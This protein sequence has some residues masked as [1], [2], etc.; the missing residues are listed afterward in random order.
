MKKKIIL[1]LS[2]VFLLAFVSVGI[3]RSSNSIE[4]F[5]FQGE[6]IEQDVTEGVTKLSTGTTRLDIKNLPYVFENTVFEV[7]TGKTFYKAEIRLYFRNGNI[8]SL[9]VFEPAFTLTRVLLTGKPKL[10]KIEIIVYYYNKIELGPWEPPV[11]IVLNPN[12]EVKLEDISTGFLNALLNAKDDI[13][14]GSAEQELINDWPR[15]EKYYDEPKLTKANNLLGK[16][17]DNSLRTLPVD[18]LTTLG[19][20]SDKDIVVYSLI[21]SKA[22]H[23]A[24]QKEILDLF[25]SESENIT[26]RNDHIAMILNQLHTHGSLLNSEMNVLVPGVQNVLNEAFEVEISTGQDL[27]YHAIEFGT[28][29]K[30]GFVAEFNLWGE[31]LYYNIIIYEK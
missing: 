4:V 11:V 24:E 8:E 16:N 28:N 22:E 25:W 31:L 7:P 10:D 1:A 17:A 5:A 29:I 14:I 3:I 19:L 15:I 9:E 23:T 2:I 18:F 27:Y 12:F 20:D 26:N 21:K 13:I 30:I 6:M